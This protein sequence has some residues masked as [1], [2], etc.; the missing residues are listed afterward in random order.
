MAEQM[1]C[2]KCGGATETRTPSASR[3][4]KQIRTTVCTNPECGHI[5]E[6]KTLSPIEDD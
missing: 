5:C 6:V 3:P 1:K 4:T 2:P